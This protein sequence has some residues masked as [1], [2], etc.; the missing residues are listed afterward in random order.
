[1]FTASASGA[2]V[3]CP[4]CRATLTDWSARC[5]KCRYHPDCDD[6]DCYNRAQDDVAMLLRYDAAPRVRRAPATGLGHAWRRLLPAA[7]RRPG[8]SAN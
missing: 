7:L 1:M 8:A 4:A 5:P 2:C 6:R 3:E